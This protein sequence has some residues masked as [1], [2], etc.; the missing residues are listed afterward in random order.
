M[1]LYSEKVIWIPF[2]LSF[3][4]VVFRHWKWQTGLTFFVLAVL[5]LAVN[6]QLC[7]SVIR[8]AVCRLRPS[9]L[10]NPVSDMVHI[11]DGYR[12]GRYGFPSAHSTNSWGLTIFV[13]LIFRN[14]RLSVSMVL[15]ATIM[16]YTRMYLG[17]HYFGDVFVGFILGTINATIFYL[18]FKRFSPNVCE[19]F[20]I[21]RSL[22]PTLDLVSWVL[23]L[24]VALMLLAA[25]VTFIID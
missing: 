24:E 1:R 3:A 7:S 15:W 9:N 17:V 23:A 16:C 2:Y 25:F 14:K 8:P 6:D 4:P 21:T 22:L 20:K 18:L 5:L 11:V 12:G 13:I 10:A 19:S